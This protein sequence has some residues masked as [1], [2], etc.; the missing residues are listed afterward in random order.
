VGW[1]RTRNLTALTAAAV[2]ITLSSGGVASAS[3]GGWVL[4]SVAPPNANSELNGVSCT[5]PTACLAVGEAYKEAPLAYAWDGT[6]WTRSYP[7][8]PAS[9][10][11]QFLA[12]SCFSAVRCMASGDYIN[13]QSLPVPFA[14]Q[15][16][17]SSW[18]L[19]SVP[20]PSGT[21]QAELSS[22]SCP[23]ANWC[24]ATG[25]EDTSA[26]LT[27]V[28][29]G[30][31][32]SIVS[33][34]AIGQTTQIDHVSCPSPS[35]CMAVGSSDS[36]TEFQTSVIETWNGTSW[37]LLADPPPLAG[38]GDGSA[39]HGVSCVTASTC[40]VS[41]FIDTAANAIKAVVLGWNGTTWTQQSFPADRTIYQVSC[42]TA[43]SCTAMGTSGD[44]SAGN[45][46]IFHGN[47]TGWGLVTT[48]L[49]SGNNVSLYGLSCS[50]GSYCAAVG[51]YEG[52]SDH[53]IDLP[54]VIAN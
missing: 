1:M 19:Q 17:G 20:M 50:R 7:V 3:G 27:E 33:S 10:E 43:T 53:R 45:P 8:K 49:P 29:N 51:V 35:F 32:W 12:V 22:I 40:T 44:N 47:G 46:Q 34:P 11:G 4:Q 13:S 24:M 5:S 26:A 36:S 38:A 9:I 23:A 16:Y 6:S 14:E 25:F 42:A 48:P 52:S 21:N 15:R 31:A 28:W 54:Y 37:T 30:T 2:V 39:L 41:G 18:K